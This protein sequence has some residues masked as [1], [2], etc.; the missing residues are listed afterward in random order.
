MAK[1]KTITF[2][3]PDTISI[4]NINEFYKTLTEFEY[5][6]KGKV[7]IDADDC[8]DIDFSG[9]QILASFV[10]TLKKEKVDFAWD[11]LSISLFQASEDLG[12]N[13]ALGL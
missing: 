9:L 12:M 6:E 13:D 2:A 10:K 8:E 11:N 5:K 4:E 7:I 3:L 1:E